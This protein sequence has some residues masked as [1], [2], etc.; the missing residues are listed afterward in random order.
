MHAAFIHSGRGDF[1]VSASPL[2]EIAYRLART[3]AGLAADIAAKNKMVATKFGISDVNFVK[4]IPTELNDKRANNDNAG[5][6]GLILA[7]VSQMME[8]DSSISINTLINYL[9]QDDEVLAY[10]LITAMNE[11]STGSEGAD[12]GVACSG[13]GNLGA[14]F[15]ST[16]EGSIKGNFAI[17]LISFYD[18]TNTVP[19]IQDYI[20]AGVSGVTIDN[21]AEV[22]AVVA[23]ATPANS[24]TAAK[25]QTLV[26]SAA[27]EPSVAASTLSASPTTVVADGKALSTITL[28]A[29]DK[30]RKNIITGGLNVTMTT[31]GDATLGDVS[32][33]TYT[34]TITNTKAESV[35]ITASIAGEDVVST[36]TVSFMPGEVSLTKSTLSASPTSV[37]ADGQTLSTITLQ[38]KDLQ[39]NNLVTGDARI[40]LRDFSGG[41]LVI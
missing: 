24:N 35:T 6:F 21:L 8:S 26:N 36:V 22:N 37:V 2:S 12:D 27:G 15:S 13:T 5:K 9:T 1:T 19:S 3:G 34:A 41:F 4:T 11:C 39:G 38:A 7:A 33:G 16:G 14:A 40:R 28:Q 18:G 20:D 10:K 17:A 25:I 23:K 29:K 31:T 32:D 30:D